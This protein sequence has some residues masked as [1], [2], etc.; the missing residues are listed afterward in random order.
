V[1]AEPESQD[2]T[3]LRNVLD[4]LEHPPASDH[5]PPGSVTVSVDDPSGVSAVTASFRAAAGRGSVVIV[6]PT[7]MRYPQVISVAKAMSDALA[8]P[9]KN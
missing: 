7:R 6:G 9:S 1:L 4:L 2:V 5:V 8:A 3:F